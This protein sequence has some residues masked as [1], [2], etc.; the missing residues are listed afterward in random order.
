MIKS[1][2]DLNTGM[3]LVKGICKVT[4]KP[5]E[6]RVPHKGYLKWKKGATVQSAMPEV[7]YDTRKFLVSETSPEGWNI[8]FKSDN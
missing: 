2:I 6:V 1:E 8:L 5:Y 3:V 4:K 7:D